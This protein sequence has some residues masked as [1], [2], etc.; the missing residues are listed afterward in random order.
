MGLESNEI[1]EES[2]P[3]EIAEALKGL[4][5]AEECENIAALENP[6][7]FLY[8]GALLFEIGKDPSKFME[9]NNLHVEL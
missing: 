7:A 9:E 2:T 4:F 1:L 5:D 8:A 6:D 3:A